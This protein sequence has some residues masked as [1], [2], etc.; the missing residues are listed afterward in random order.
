MAILL[1]SACAKRAATPGQ[2]L[3]NA[4][5]TYDVMNAR[6]SKLTNCEPMSPEAMQELRVMGVKSETTW[7][8]V[9]I[10][11]CDPSLPIARM[12]RL[13][14]FDLNQMYDDLKA[15]RNFNLEYHSLYRK[16]AELHNK[17]AHIRNQLSVQKEYLEEVN[18]RY[19]QAMI[20]QVNRRLLLQRL[21]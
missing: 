5:E 3:A 19:T 15:M 6:Y 8:E 18:T 7:S 14:K 10:F 11:G 4:Q 13:L 2:A 12:A 20:A 16:L 21:R 17:I 1:L 9:F